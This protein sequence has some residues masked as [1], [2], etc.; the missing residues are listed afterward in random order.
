LPI[1]GALIA[2]RPLKIVN[3]TKDVSFPPAGYEPVQQCL[4]PV[5]EWYGAADKLAEHHEVTGHV[6][7]P[8]YRK[9]ANEWLNQWLRDDRTPFDE[10]GIEKEEDVSRLLVLKQYP[11]DAVNEGIHRSFIPAHKQREWKT[12]AEWNK[13]RQELIAARQGLSGRA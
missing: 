5:Y 4:R 9:A 2:P 12:A 1:V 3:A 8:P 11:P 7:T 13:R 6:D 10:S